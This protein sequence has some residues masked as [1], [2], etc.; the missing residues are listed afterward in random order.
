MVVSAIVCLG[1]LLSYVMLGIYAERK[2]A[3]FMQSRLGPYE[4]GPYGLLQSFADILKLIQKEDIIPAKADKYL[5]RLAPWVVFLPVFAGMS[6]LP[7]FSFLHVVRIETGALLL[8]GVLGLDV[9]GILMAGYGTANKLSLYGGLRAMGQLLSYEVV[10]GLC[11][12]C[13]VF[14][15]Q[16]MDIYEIALQ[17]SPSSERSAPLLGL[18]PKI[19]AM[20]WGGFFTWNIF[21]LPLLFPVF[22]LFFIA[23]VV[24]S[25]R[26]PFDLAESESEL[27][28]GYHT[29]YTGFRWTVFM[30]S[31]YAI[32]LILSFL[33]VFLFLGGGSSPL[34]N[35]GHLPLSDWTNAPPQSAG[36]TLWLCGKTLGLIFMHMWIRWS[37]PRMRVD[38]LMLF[39]WRIL[40]PLCICFVYLTGLWCILLF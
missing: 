22:V 28:G 1:F 35:I 13:V 23:S 20:S 27:V 14:L 36:Y 21:R 40:I 5:M 37:Y 25:N 18:F 3:A 12:V 10:L 34:P 8:L 11:L 2:I 16:S 32:M 30:L 7:I 24:E 9:I 31:E 15:T 26:I 33:A 19:D 38:Q 39:S 6:L 29:E 4:V 17:Q